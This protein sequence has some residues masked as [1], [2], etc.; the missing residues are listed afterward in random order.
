MKTLA[1]AALGFALMVMQGDQ[2]PYQRGTYQT[3]E[4]CTVAGQA[5]VA[6]LGAAWECVPE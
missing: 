2:P 5:E 3:F 1:L 4:E 6:T